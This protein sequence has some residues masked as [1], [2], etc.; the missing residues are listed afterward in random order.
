MVT[1]IRALVVLPTKDLSF[2]VYKVFKQF[3]IDTNLKVICL[4]NSSLEKEKDKL[5]AIG[6]KNK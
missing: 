6:N 3:V 4:G 1:R 2:Q 5:V